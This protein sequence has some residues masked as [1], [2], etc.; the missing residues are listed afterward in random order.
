MSQDLAFQQIDGSRPAQT[1]AFLHGILGSGK[2]LRTVAT[3]FLESRPAWSAWLVD[4]R[5][6]GQSPK[7]T[8]GPS[9]EAA[10][11][12]VIALAARAGAP[13]SAIAG[14]S[15]GGKVALEIARIGEIG[16]LRDVI[17]IDSVP[18]AR[19]PVAEGDSPLAILN[20]LESLPPEFESISS[21]VTSL[22]AAGL[23]R[24]LAQWLGSSVQREGDRVRFGLDVAEICALVLDYYARDLW[25][26][27]ENPP[28]GL[29]VHLIVGD[30][31]SS[32]SP[33]DRRRAAGIAAENDRVTM[34]VLPAGHWV[35][36]DDP[37]GLLRSLLRY[38]A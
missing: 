6:H 36:V 14:H 11:R 5:G 19:E 23:A 2:N 38:L 25:P 24:D 31:S 28:K 20:I 3:R 33:E 15:F 7:G 18:S 35:H 37:E 26:V 1:I 16:S 9:I 8:P 22:E 4:L 34:D 10:A 29:R 13:L 30:Q 12:D 27:V 32:Y 21:F 17:T